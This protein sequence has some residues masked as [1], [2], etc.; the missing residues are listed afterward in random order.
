MRG[1]LLAA[2]L[3]SAF[4]T[5]PLAASSAPSV[6]DKA[7]E[8]ASAQTG[9]PLDILLAVTRSETGRT[10]K[11]LLT[12]WP[13]TV[14]ME[15]AG[16]WFTS[17]DEALGY[18]SKHQRR[19]ARSFDVGCFQINYKWHGRNFSSVKEMF[20]PDLNALY[21]ARF[22]KQLQGNSKDWID[23]V[24]AYHS[25]TPEHSA[26][27]KR[28]FNEIIASLDETGGAPTTSLG[29]QTFFG[30]LDAPPKPA[31]KQVNAYPFLKIAATKA[32]FGSLVPLGDSEA[33]ARSLI[34]C[35]E[36]NK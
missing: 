29:G 10:D 27:Y 25:R 6:C 18:V 36:K 1:C 31:V 28:R 21:A 7:A 30:Q 16:K 26:K 15:G 22:L 24:G 4:G 12:P 34:Y 33:G 17:Q 14:N 5:V 19:G 2:L 3:C 8:R 20:D 9:V 23:A 11:G 32:R 35:P 13:W